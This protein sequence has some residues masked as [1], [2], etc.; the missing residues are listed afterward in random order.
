MKKLSLKKLSGQVVVITGASSG[1]GLVTARMAARYGTRLVLN[2]RNEE[3]LKQVIEEIHAA[4]GQA[5]HVSGDVSR[6]ED[7]RRI[8]E[9]AVRQFGGFDTWINNAGVSIYG[10]LT[11]IPLEDMRRLFDINFWGVVY[12]SRVAIEHLRHRGGALI[13]VG[14]AVSDRAI[15]LQGIYSASKHAVKGFTDALR[16][17]VE[18]QGA[19]ISITLVKP[20]SIDTPLPEH[21]RNYMPVEPKLPPPVYAPELAAEA[22]LHAAEHPVR[23]VFVGSGGKGIAAIGRFSPRLMD[24]FMEKSLFHMQQTDEPSREPSGSL[25]SAGVDLRERGN[26]PGSTRETSVYTTASLHPFVAGAVAMGA[27]LALVAW[28]G[29]RRG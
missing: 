4:G 20:G 16:M 14:S 25:Y 5:I 26:H 22:I 21:A 8:A 1:I 10:R 17:E 9:E 27:G 2:S 15:P 19:A 11:Q 24:R 29:G 18:E 6:E 3:A 7:V 23:D 28:F 12:G 13:N